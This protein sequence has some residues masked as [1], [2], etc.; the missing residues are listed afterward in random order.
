MGLNWNEVAYAKLTAQAISE[1]QE[2]DNPQEITDSIITITP[3]VIGIETIV[4]DRTKLRISQNALGEQAGLAQNAIERKRDVDLLSAFSG[5]T[6]TLAGT[7]TTL[8]TGHISAAGVRVQGNTTEPWDGPRVAVLHSF[9]VK[10]L[11]DEAVSGF[12]TYP[13]PTGLSQEIFQNAWKGPIGGVDVV[14]DDNITIDGT[15]DARGAVFAR[16]ANGALVHVRGRSPWMAVERKQ[17][18]GGA[19]AIFHYDE[20]ATAERGGGVWMFGLLSDA[21]V[22]TS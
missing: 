2:Y 20:Y 14:I 12:G 7:G 6:T 4:T 5:A 1:T 19:D 18:G 21:T 11:F 13:F 15:P 10:D 17:I 22:P 3:T 9:Q 8:T 16:G